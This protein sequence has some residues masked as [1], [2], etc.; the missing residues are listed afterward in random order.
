MKKLNLWLGL[1]F[2]FCLA[3]FQCKKSENGTPVSPNTNYGRTITL[4]DNTI[5]YRNIQ[6]GWLTRD[7]GTRQYYTLFHAI[8][9]FH[10]QIFIDVA[11]ED[12][13]LRVLPNDYTTT[14]LLEN[15]QKGKARI[16]VGNL[17]NLFILD[18]SQS[19]KISESDGNLRILIDNKK[20]S[21]DSLGT[22]VSVNVFANFSLPK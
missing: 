14:Y 13:N 21:M 12:S 5:Q 10:I 1:V 11:V 7:S 15:L 16:S 19:V 3:N 4:T 20:A 6:G 17:L 9:S 8:D 18:S 22:K 2:V